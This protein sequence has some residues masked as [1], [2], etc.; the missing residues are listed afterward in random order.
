[1]AYNEGVPDDLDDGELELLEALRE[2]EEAQR[3]R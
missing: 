2:H 3:K 1:V